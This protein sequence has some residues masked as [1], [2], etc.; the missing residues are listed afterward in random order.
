MRPQPYTENC[1]PLRK[2]ESRRNSLPQERARQLLIQYQ[3]VSPEHTH[4][5]THTPFY[6]RAWVMC[7]GIYVYV[8]KTTDI[9]SYYVQVR[10]I[11]GHEFEREQGR[12]YGKAWREKRGK[13]CNSQKIGR[14]RRKEE[15]E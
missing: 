4:T 7:L 12:A 9:H 10:K 11:R 15:E 6:K 1:R 5:H 3:M 8:F 2:A 14:R 13:W